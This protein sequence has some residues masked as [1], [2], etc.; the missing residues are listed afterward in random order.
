M[1]EMARDYVQGAIMPDGFFSES[2]NRRVREFVKLFED[3]YAE[4]PG[5]IEATAYDT[6]MMLFQI[7]QH[8]D[9]QSRTAIK[10]ELL[11]LRDFPGVTGLTSFDGQR[12]AHKE[13]SMLRI[14]GDGFVELK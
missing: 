4:T 3:T 9:V 8:P 14:E 6:A 13:L 2:Q 12:E 1:I 7:C 10:E 5:V 11:R